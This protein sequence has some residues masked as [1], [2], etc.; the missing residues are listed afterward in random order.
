MAVSGATSLLWDK[1][2]E[3]CDKIFTARCFRVAGFSCT[4][5]ARIARFMRLI[6]V[7]DTFPPDINGVARTLQ[8]LALGL[9]ARG[10]QVAVVTTLDAE[11]DQEQCPERHIVASWPIPGYNML[12]VGFA[13][14]AWFAALFREQQTDV[15]YVATETPLGVAA[16]WAAH[17]A[18]LHVV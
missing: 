11:P 2:A 5:S 7:S 8:Q 13:S 3:H 15:L 1:S 12:R 4:L 6:I 18:G 16:S 10:H 17:R 9:L 14:M